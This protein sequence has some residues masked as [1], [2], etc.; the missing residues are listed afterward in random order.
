[1]LRGEEVHLDKLREWER[2][3]YVRRYRRIYEELP[4]CTTLDFAERGPAIYYA[5]PEGYDLITEEPRD[6]S[7]GD[8]S[9]A[10]G[11]KRRRP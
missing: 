4:V 1:M 3:D 9:S 2:T 6:D 10:A 7:D 5:E 8:G 11:R